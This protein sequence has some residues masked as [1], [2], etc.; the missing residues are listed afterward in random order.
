M[1]LHLSADREHRVPQLA[2]TSGQRAARAAYGRY[3]PKVAN[4]PSF[5]RAICGDVNGDGTVSVTDGVNVLR[6]AAGLP[7][8]LQCGTAPST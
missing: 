3:V 1:A 8:N 5:A 7:A 4:R 6:A 2:S